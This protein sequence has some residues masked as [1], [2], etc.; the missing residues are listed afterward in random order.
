MD[1]DY[2]TETRI[3]NVRNAKDNLNKPSHA[4]DSSTTTTDTASPTPQLT[5][6]GP[7]PSTS[8]ATTR[9][10]DA[11]THI[12]PAV[13]RALFRLPHLTRRETHVLLIDTFR[14]RTLDDCRISELKYGVH[15]SEDPLP[16]FLD[17]VA[18]A[19]KADL[20]PWWWD[21]DARSRCVVMAGGREGDACVFVE[22]RTEELERRYGD[23]P[24]VFMMRIMAQWVYGK[25][26]G[27]DS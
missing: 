17:F 16:Y 20:M 19:E 8:M 2:T 26:V 6:T 14:L 24:V 11:Y 25:G 15:A 23:Q 12:A 27:E 21:E 10:S 5:L 9:E 7:M 13:N 1:Q 4:T 18:L 22:V 3:N